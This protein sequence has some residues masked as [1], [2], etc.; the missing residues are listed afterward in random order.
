MKIKVK[1]KANSSKEEIKK[2]SETE[3]ILSVKE[4]PIEN[5]ANEAVLKLLS[6]Y[7][8]VPKSNISILKGQTSKNKIIQILY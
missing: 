4:P 8:N 7:F 1:V 3:F 5:K 6:E 2:I